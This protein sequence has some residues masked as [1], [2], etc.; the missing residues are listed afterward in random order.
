MMSEFNDN[1]ML[2]EKVARLVETMDNSFTEGDRAWLGNLE[3][4]WSHSR[5]EVFGLS[6]AALALDTALI[7]ADGVSKDRSMILAAV[8]RGLASEG[9]PLLDMDDDT[10]SLVANLEGVEGVLSQSFRGQGTDGVREENFRRLLVC[11]ARDVRVV[12]ILVADRLALMRAINRHPRQEEVR[13]IALE[14]R[15]LYAALAHRLG[16]YA[17]KG[18]LE[19]LSLKYLDR[20]VYTAIAHRLNET[21]AV[22]DEYIQNF[23]TPVKAKLEAEG[24]RFQIKGRTK[25]IF[26]IWNK[27]KKQGVDLDGI[28]D[29]F[30]I[31]II[32]DAEPEREK[33]VCWQ[34]FSIV[35][36][37]FR[38]NPARMKDWIS[39][40]KTNGY[41]S[42]H[43]TVYGPDGRW[44]EV[45]IRSRRMDDIAERGVAAHW[46]YKE[47]KG[48]SDGGSVDAWLTGIREILE[49]AK[50]E[51]FRFKPV[52]EKEV[53]VFTPK[54]DVYNLPAGAT[55]LDFAFHIHTGLG[56]KTIGGIVGG[57]P[58]K[59]NYRLRS[60]DTVEVKTASTQ[61]PKTAWLDFV[62]TGRARAKIRAALKEQE[63]RATEIGK[64]LL[65]RRFKNRKIELHEAELMKSIKKLG[66]KTSTDFYSA[67]GL[68]NLDINNVLD[69]Y[70]AILSSEKNMAEVPSA[71]E[72]AMRHVD[73]HEVS[74]DSGED[75]LIIGEGVKGMN[76]RMAKCCNPIFG[77]DVFGFISSEGVVKIH[78]KECPNARNITQKYPYRIIKT[79]WSGRYDGQMAATL[80]IVGRDD[81]GIVTNI[82]SI[83]NKESGST[84][85]NISI[86]SSAGLFQG[87]VVVGVK[88][89]QT[90]DNLIKKIK[91][92][93][94]VKDVQRSK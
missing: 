90:L 61:T 23:I 36:D 53:F 91:T 85:R 45:Q 2:Q 16:L 38:Y 57:K 64:E 39:I 37:M 8:A 88:D 44:V 59:I 66:Y 65:H 72:F 79:R 13:R 21:K 35:T 19:D 24:I 87:Y 22:R 40:P 31:R 56:C 7:L 58:R 48:A 18:E 43:T 9:R 29:L 84:L 17:I 10:R 28:Y 11:V 83:I 50:N 75:V 92:V 1:I 12:M 47:G 62:V 71:D 70:T 34:V 55:L 5:D 81:I 25:S 27:I 49:T 68:E 76:F 52:E 77:D 93:K 3:G 42:L 14:A 51:D 20:D 89:I 6:K 74:S 46:M 80:R 82:T 32:V 78:R 54:G 63:S 33:M 4:V 41:E 67:L 60:G 30:A 86:D 69:T 15:W 26:S 94:G 73:G